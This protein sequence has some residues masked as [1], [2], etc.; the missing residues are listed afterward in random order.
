VGFGVDD[1]LIIGLMSFIKMTS[2]ELTV[3]DVT[4]KG[5]ALNYFNGRQSAH[6]RF[7]L[8]LSFEFEYRKSYTIKGDTTTG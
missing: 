5:G 4:W 6:K 7:N 2:R 1:H 8:F 3:E